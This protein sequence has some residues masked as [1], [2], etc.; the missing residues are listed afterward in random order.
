MAPQLKE[1]QP[2]AY[3]ESKDIR[4]IPGHEDAF[5]VALRGPIESTELQLA[6]PVPIFTESNVKGLPL[7]RPRFAG[8]EY[9]VT[10]R[11]DNAGSALSATVL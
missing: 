1:N 7:K 5:L 9:K 10:M 3:V 2:Y 11:S 8:T 6:D 4:G